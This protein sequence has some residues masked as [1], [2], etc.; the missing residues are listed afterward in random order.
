MTDIPRPRSSGANTGSD[1]GSDTGS[2]LGSDAWPDGGTT[3][4]TD[5][6]LGEALAR[7]IDEHVGAVDPLPPSDIAERA[8]A[9]ARAR[10]SRRA[11]AALV[12]AAVVLVGGVVVWN[13]LDP[14]EDSDSVVITSDDAASPAV[15]GDDAT[16][17]GDG[18]QS[19]PGQSEAA[20]AAV[21]TGSDQAAAAD[22]GSPEATA[23][24]TD[25]SGEGAAASDEPADSSSVTPE[26]LSTGPVLTWSEISPPFSDAI[27]LES[28]GDGRV[29]ARLRDGADGRVSVTS[30]G[31][32]WTDVPM[33]DGIDVRH[34]D[35]SGRRWL[36]TGTGLAD[37]EDGSGSAGLGWLASSPEGP[38][39]VF[40]SDDRGAAWTELALEMPTEPKPPY[41]VTQPWVTHA[42][43][44]GENM[45]LVVLG[46]E[47]FD[48]EA[49]LA[50][51]GFVPEGQRVIGWSTHTDY[52]GGTLSGTTLK[53]TLGDPDDYPGQALWGASV[54]SSGTASSSGS[55]GSSDSSDSADSSG[56]SDSSDSSG[57]GDS[58]GSSGSAGSSGSGVGHIEAWRSADAASVEVSFDEL[59]LTA[60]Q[61][62]VLSG[63]HFAADGL[64]FWSDGGAF[65]LAAE[66]EYWGTRGLATGDG[67]VLLG[68]VDGPPLEGRRALLS[69]DG[70]TWSEQTLEAASY[71]M[72]EA[73]VGADGYTIWSASGSFG[74]QFSLQIYRYG[75]DLE[76]VATFDQPLDLARI[77][78]G[79]AGLALTAHVQADDGGA[80]DGDLL[81]PEGRVAKDGYELRYGEPT[82]GITLWD[83]SEDAAVYVFGPEAVASETT[84]QGVREIDDE[85]QFAVVFEDLDTGEELVTFT[86]EDL[87]EVFGT[88]YDSADFQYPETWV[89]WSADGAEWG[90]QKATEAFGLDG[91]DV[92]VQLAVGGDFVLARVEAVE[93]IVPASSPGE[94]D[95]AQASSELL[96][97][98]AQPPRWFIARVP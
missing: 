86:M 21:P 90:W 87:S 72:G 9:R 41:V 91:D 15:T 80:Y 18:S 38:T 11:A 84:P 23:A 56:S 77:A 66:H 14:F 68:F 48:V 3:A 35:V 60:D 36:V 16:A 57:S 26:Q 40:Y 53:F 47:T 65:E 89:G 25:G 59:G 27:L 64:I 1:S 6:G 24:D 46:T 44:S 95:D 2:A 37:A 50:D 28:P 32:N 96:V 31:V 82:G 61:R 54:G 19:Q 10:A 92:W 4:P 74:G 20:G 30:D 81:M 8:E 73:V 97:R 62:S 7:A 58:S 39:R 17:T 51:K 29:V 52:Q 83:L 55:S 78:V 71:R 76:T 70:R 45:V 63:D 43:T 93:T 33:P 67:F 69:P 85:G 88:A 75:E 49:L 34:V 12:A 13:A 22:G 79:P 42:L 94:E 98:R 5:D